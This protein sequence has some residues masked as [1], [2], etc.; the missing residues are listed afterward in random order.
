MF[1]FK[2]V[3]DE[4]CSDNGINGWEFIIINFFEDN[5]VLFVEVLNFVLWGSYEVVVE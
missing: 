4:L 5:D 2:D 3:V 1:D